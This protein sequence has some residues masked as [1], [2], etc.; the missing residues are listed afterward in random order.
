MLLLI[1]TIATTNAEQIKNV[2]L[3]IRDFVKLSYFIAYCPF[4][5]IYWPTS[6]RNDS[7]AQLERHRR[8]Q[9]SGFRITDA[10]I[11]NAAI[12]KCFTKD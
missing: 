3:I 2:H 7:S 8:Y 9:V 1:I 10:G 4:T 12:E 11:A 6:E 5:E